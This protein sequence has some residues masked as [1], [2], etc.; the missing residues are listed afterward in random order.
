MYRAI[1][2]ISKRRIVTV[3]IAVSMFVGAGIAAAEGAKWSD[4]PPTF[5]EPAPA[6]DEVTTTSP[7][8]DPTVAVDSTT[9]ESTEATTPR[10]THETATDINTSTIDEQPSV[11][12]TEAT[13]NPTTNPTTV[14]VPE[15]TPPSVNEPTT[16]A[17]ALP[18]QP[19]PTTTE[20][21]DTLVPQGIS[22][23]CTATGGTVSCSW[24]SPDVPGFARV[25]LLRGDGGTQGR[26][27][28][29]SNNSSSVSYID[30]NVPAGSYS[31]IVVVLDGNSLTLVH[32]NP[33]L[34][35]IGAVG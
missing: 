11:P 14:P 30:P 21:H 20:F 4:T 28:F 12:T 34:I 16:T 2:L 33:V 31:Y 29:Q 35:T 8:T 24:S 6:A 3:G 25:L 1:R 22:L 23:I 9:P 27:P 10:V 32:S 7:S 18:E 15:P 17:A 26:V 19:A 13:T 5:A